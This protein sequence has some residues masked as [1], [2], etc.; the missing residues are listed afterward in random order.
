MK[1][2]EAQYSLEDYF[3]SKVGNRQVVQEN[4]VFKAVLT[5]YQ[6]RNSKYI[7]PYGNKDWI[8]N[9]VLAIVRWEFRRAIILS[10]A[11]WES[12]ANQLQDNLKQKLGL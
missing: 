4:E 8:P 6:Y 11:D 12:F 10:V 1:M 3:L 9:S 7:E 2:Y 5:S